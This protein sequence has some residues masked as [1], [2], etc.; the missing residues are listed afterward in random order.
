MRGRTTLLIAH[1]LHTIARAD[2]IVVLNEGRI[3]EA[4]MHVELLER[5]GFYHRLLM[6]GQ[7]MKDA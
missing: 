6:V 2:R 5:K 4:G 7:R 1:R 3:E